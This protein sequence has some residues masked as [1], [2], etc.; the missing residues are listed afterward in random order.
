MKVTTK[1]SLERILEKEKGVIIP[2]DHGVSDGPIAGLEDINEAV[3]LADAG[4]ASAVLLHKGM[5]KQLVKRPKCGIIMHVSAGTKMSPDPNR[6]VLVGDV[7]DALRLKADAVS[8][9]INVGGSDYEAEMLEDLGMLSSQCDEAGLPL[10]A[11]MYPRGKNVTNAS[12]EIIAHVARLG[13]ELGADL[14]K[15]P[16]TGD[17]DSFKQVVRGCPVPV[18]IAGGPKCNTDEDVLRMVKGAIDGGA[19]GI[20]LGRNAFQHKNP[21]KMVSALRSIIVHNAS[22][23]D[24]LKLLK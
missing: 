2:M 14:I 8:I 17:P 10:L 18:L 22:V 15:C 16:Y 1:K 5:I 11:M 23:E 9:H 21:S 6:K 7:E 13:A 3:R 12:P 19:K 24:A 4:G 20:S